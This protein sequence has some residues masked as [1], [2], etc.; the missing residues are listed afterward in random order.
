[1]VALFITAFS[2]KA[3]FSS[4]DRP[5]NVQTLKNTPKMASFLACGGLQREVK[6]PAH[7]N[8]LSAAYDR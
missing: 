8:R 1:V 4:P 5:E 6:L 3:V 2:N 7:F